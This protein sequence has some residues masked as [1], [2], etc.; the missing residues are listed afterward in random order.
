[1][2]TK[3]QQIAIVT[4]ANGGIGKNYTRMML[5]DGFRVVMAVRNEV[6]GSLVRDELLQSHPDAAI[7]ILKVD[8][9]SLSSI[10]AFSKQVK[11]KYSRIDVLAHNAGVYFFDN[12]RRESTDGIELNLAV[13]VVGPYALTI[14]LLPLLKETQ[15]SRVITMSSS[16]HHGA[17]IDLRDIQIKERF[18]EQGNMIAYSRSKWAGLGWH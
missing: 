17:K 4:G 8:M 13:H 7:D 18:E 3:Q 15:G 9:S 2:N 12:E 5:D 11:E 10:K 1:M 16:E 6:A 14:Q